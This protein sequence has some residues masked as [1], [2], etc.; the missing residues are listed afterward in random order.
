MLTKTPIGTKK[1]LT[2]T[3]VGTRKTSHFKNN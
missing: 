1:I 2:K 3:P